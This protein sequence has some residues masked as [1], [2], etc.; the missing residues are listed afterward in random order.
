MGRKAARKGSLLAFWISV[1]FRQAKLPVVCGDEACDVDP[2]LAKV[3]EL[4]L[5][6]LPA[7]QFPTVFHGVLSALPGGL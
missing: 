5:A 1:P 7:P 4:G 3:A 2:N 6:V